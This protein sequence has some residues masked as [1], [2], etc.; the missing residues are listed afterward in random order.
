MRSKGFTLIELLVV[1]AIIA[2]LAAMLLPALSRAR[3]KARQSVCISN[4]KQIGLGFEMYAN[5]HNGTICLVD[6]NI[7][8]PSG[9]KGEWSEFLV[10]GGYITNQSIFYCPSRRPDPSGTT[11][12]TVPTSSPEYKT[13]GAGIDVPEEYCVGIYVLDD[14]VDKWSI[15]VKKDKI[16]SVSTYVMVA[17]TAAMGN[18]SFYGVLGEAMYF[19]RNFANYD[20]ETAVFINHAGIANC[21]FDDGHVEGVP[22]AK[23][24]T[25]GIDHYVTSKGIHVKP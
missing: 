15:Y 4:L 8:F 13:Y 9:R 17:D 5:D 7:T 2:I 16:P 19:V 10:N 18:T 6:E 21:L 24:S 14:S 11:G 23:L 22:A 20:E 25:Y 1:I 3:E 12:S